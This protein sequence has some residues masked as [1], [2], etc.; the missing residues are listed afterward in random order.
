MPEGS[1]WRDRVSSRRSFLKY[2]AAGGATLLAG[3]GG[4][5]DPTTTSGGTGTTN[6][7]GG[8]ST[9]TASFRLFDPL[10][11]G[12]LPTERHFNP[13]NPTQSGCWHPGAC[14]F[15]RPVVYS[16]T[17]NEAYSLM[18]KSWEMTGDTTLEVTFS[19][20]W[21]W[22]NGDQ[23]VAQD[24]VMQQQIENEIVAAGDSDSDPLIKS[25]EATDDFHARIELNKPLSQ[26]FAVQNTIGIYNGNLARG[27]FTKHDD[28]KWSDWHKRLRNSSGEEKMS[29]VEEITSAT[30]PMINSDEEWIGHGP[31]QISEVGDD[32]IVMTKY[33][34]HP[35][36]D[37]INFDQFVLKEFTQN[38]PFQPYANGLVDGAFTGF[39]VKDSLRSQLPSGTT[40]YREGRSSNKLISFNC[41][42]NVEQESP[43]N[44]NN[45]RK[46]IAHVYDRQRVKPLLQGVQRIFEWAPCRVPGKVL[47]EGEVKPTEWVQDFT[48]YGQNDTERATQLLKGEGYTL[49][50]GKWYTPNGDRFQ[51]SIMNGAKAQQI[52]VL[53]QCLKEFGIAVEQEQVDD[54]TFDQRRKNGNFD[55]MPDGSS[56]NGLTAM[57]S[58]GLLAEWVQ[59]ITHFNPNAE[60][61]MPVGDPSGSSGTKEINVRDHIL[62][63]Q[64]TNDPQYHKELM[65]WWNQTLPEIEVLYEPDA[66]A[67]NGSNWSMTVR[68]GIK[69]GVDDAIYI[70]PKMGGLKMK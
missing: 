14:V 17:K 63:W 45:V 42:Y 15:D 50:G 3:C 4:S 56:A 7:N 8:G 13:W 62:K 34:D 28:D 60:I 1:N 51:I 10:T 31:F 35:H 12:A 33:E 29:V 5:S 57:W 38:K 24:W 36:A 48:L 9:D 49:E 21:T 47:S 20:Q 37:Q 27:V 70:A 6:Q 23:F 54:A 26:I 39:P 55:I 65:W 64:S 32:R 18:A 66:G 61:P 53:K 44:N 16:P 69:N 30:Y 40:L 68:D 52:Q 2:G 41:G 58:V 25:V 19:D 22:H 59:S 67:Y 43:M 11:S 46:A